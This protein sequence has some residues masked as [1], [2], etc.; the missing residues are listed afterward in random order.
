MGQFDGKTVFITG[1][2]RGSGS[3]ARARA[4]GR[5]RGVL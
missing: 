5:R 1:G 4:G 3:I 2:A